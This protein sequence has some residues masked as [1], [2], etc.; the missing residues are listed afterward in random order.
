MDLE[1]FNRE[2]RSST[3]MSMNDG[4]LD[5]WDVAYHPF[6]KRFHPHIK[7]DEG[8]GWK[9][10]EHVLDEHQDQQNELPQF[11]RVMRYQINSSKFR[12]TE[13]SIKNRLHIM[14]ILSKLYLDRPL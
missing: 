7:R 10:D 5:Y 11:L 4:T 8:Y 13:S 3:G 6:S 9:R 12:Y 1:N 14:H 2:T